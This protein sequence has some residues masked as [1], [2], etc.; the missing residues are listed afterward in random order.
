MNSFFLRLAVFV[1]GALVLSAGTCFSADYQAMTNEELSAIRGTH[2]NATQEERDAFRAAWTSRLDRMTPAERER[3]AGTGMG[4]GNGLKD[5]TGVSGGPG[6]GPGGRG[7]NGNSGGGSGNGPG[8]E[9]AAEM[10]GTAVGMA[11]ARA[12]GEMRAGRGFEVTSETSSS[13]HH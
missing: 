8:M 1:T 12:V 7:G 9:V 6:S 13:H 11:T 5:G 3:F 2:S 10:V 4:S